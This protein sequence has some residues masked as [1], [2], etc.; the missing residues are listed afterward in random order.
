MSIFLSLPDKYV[1]KAVYTLLN[2]ITVNSNTIKCYDSRITGS[3]I[4]SYYILMTTQTNQV[5]ESVKCGNRWQSSILLDIVTRYNASGNTGSRLLAD[6]IAEYVRNVLEADLTLEGG[7]NVIK[8][9]LDFPNDL[10]S[11]TE[12]ENIFRKFIRIELTIN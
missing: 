11:V 2:N 1:R 5:D 9:K 8:Q 4:P 10:S 7:L 3:T 12:N 6:D